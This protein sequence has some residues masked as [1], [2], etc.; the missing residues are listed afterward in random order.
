MRAMSQEGDRP[1]ERV[2]VLGGSF[3]PPHVAHAILAQELSE[4]LELDRLLVVPAAD[5]PHR[6]VV[7]PSQVRL[8]LVRRLFSGAAGIEVSSLEYERP[9]PS[10]TVDTLEALRGMLPGAH[11]VLIMGTDQFAVLDTWRSFERLPELAEIVVMRRLGEEPKPPPGVDE[12]EYTVVDVVRIDV[13]ASQI[14]ERLRLGRSI[15]FLVPET[16]RADIEREWVES[17]KC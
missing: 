11:I 16:I 8:G 6:D 12:I 4:T 15:R 2:G 10:Y 1:R 13:S 7:L 3:D 9:G 5:P 17:T 14:R